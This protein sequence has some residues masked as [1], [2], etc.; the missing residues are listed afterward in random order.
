MRK[1]STKLVLFV[2]RAY[3]LLLSPYMPGRCRYTPT[4]SQ[5]ATEAV[6]RHGAAR[7]TLLTARRLYNCTTWRGAGVD[8]VPPSELV[9]PIE[10]V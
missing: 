8:P 9:Q 10:P 1:L 2:L 4:C 3:T 6:A 5:Y 7:G